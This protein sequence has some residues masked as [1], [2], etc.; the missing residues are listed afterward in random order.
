MRLRFLRRTR[1]L[2]FLFL[3]GFSWFVY[4]DL[5]TNFCVEETSCITTAYFFRDYILRSLHLAFPL[6]T[7]FASDDI[8]LDRIIVIAHTDKEDVAWVKKRLPE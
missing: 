3:L 6:D 1:L 5:T 2:I 8:L 4:W 7:V